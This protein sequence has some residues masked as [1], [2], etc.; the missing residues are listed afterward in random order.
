MEEVAPFPLKLVS[1]CDFNTR[2]DQPM[3][4]DPRFLLSTI[5]TCA[6]Y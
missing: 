1:L 5:D 6:F 3:K 2:V 4:Y